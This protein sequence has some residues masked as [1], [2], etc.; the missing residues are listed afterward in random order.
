MA[1]GETLRAAALHPVGMVLQWDPDLIFRQCRASEWASKDTWEP[2][3]DTLIPQFPFNILYLVLFECWLW[4]YVYWKYSL[5]SGCWVC[6]ESPV[7]LVLS[8]KQR[9]QQY[10]ELLLPSVSFHFMFLQHTWGQS[11]VQHVAMAASH[12]NL[13][14][15]EELKNVMLSSSV[16]PRDFCRCLVFWG[17]VPKQFDPPMRLKNPVWWKIYFPAVQRWCAICGWD[18]AFMDQFAVEL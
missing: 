17:I 12:L 15:K 13:L 11:G 14:K 4:P 2:G 8:S 9:N 18:K 5:A 6:L 10:R 1:S 16:V 3:V 7:C